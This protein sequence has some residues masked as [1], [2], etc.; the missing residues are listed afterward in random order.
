M[1]NEKSSNRNF[2]NF[3]FILTIEQNIRLLTK[4]I[5]KETI[6]VTLVVELRKPLPHQIDTTQN[7]W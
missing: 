2:V 6:L 7:I 3:I 5:T 4:H 1:N